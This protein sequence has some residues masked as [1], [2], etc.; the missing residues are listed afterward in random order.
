MTKLMAVLDANQIVLNIIVCD[1]EQPETDFQIDIPE[2]QNA[3]I[4]GDFFEGFFYP[5]KPFQSWIRDGSGTWVSPKP[6]P[7]GE[8]YWDEELGEWINV[9]QSEA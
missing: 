5:E 7:E 8:A 3:F 2:N 9:E 4:D 6:K 1:D